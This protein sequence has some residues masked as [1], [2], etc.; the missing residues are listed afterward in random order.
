M[1]ED[2]KGDIEGTN[3]GTENSSGGGGYW[4]WRNNSFNKTLSQISLEKLGMGESTPSESDRPLTNLQHKLRNS[5]RKSFQHL[6]SNSLSRLDENDTTEKK[7]STWKESLH[8]F[9]DS[10]AN[11][12]LAGAS[13]TVG[14]DEILTEVDPADGGNDMDEDA[15][16]F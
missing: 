10:F 4:F 2:E 3:Q 15:I 14:E 13:N 7:S 11:L 12:K 6:S 1:S 16:T 8:A 9:R 5:W